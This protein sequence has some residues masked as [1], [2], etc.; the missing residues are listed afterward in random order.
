[1][2]C[3]NSEKL[4]ILCYLHPCICF[5]QCLSTIFFNVLTLSSLVPVSLSEKCH[6]YRPCAGL[7][8]VFPIKK[9]RTGYDV[10]LFWEHVGFYRSL[11]NMLFQ[12]KF[13]AYFFDNSYEVNALE[14]FFTKYGFTS[15]IVIMLGQRETIARLSRKIKDSHYRKAC[16]LGL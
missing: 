14:S 7:F 16:I 1:M 13:L 12:R 8:Y 2:F 4:Y 9:W 5:R 11:F 3:N 10:P 15:F 6:E